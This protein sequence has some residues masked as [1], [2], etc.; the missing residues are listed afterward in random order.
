[1]NER[2]IHRLL[3]GSGV[4]S[5]APVGSRVTCSPAPTDTDED[6]LVWV[7][8]LQRADEILVAAGWVFGGNETSGGNDFVSWRKDD[9]NLIVTDDMEFY[10]KFMLA[11]NLAKRFNLLDKADRIA[12][13][14]GVMYGHETSRPTLDVPF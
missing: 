11:S 10:G 1:M 3:N 7:A 14:Q 4:I 12:L 8:I 6:H 9:V 5:S 13:F 2:D